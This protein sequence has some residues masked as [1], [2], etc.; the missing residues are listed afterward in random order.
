MLHPRTKY[1]GHITP[2]NLLNDHLFKTATF[3]SPQGSR[4]GEVWLY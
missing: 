4:C 3:L 1:R 2:L